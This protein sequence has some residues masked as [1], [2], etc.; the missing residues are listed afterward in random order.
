MSLQR[1]KFQDSASLPRILEF[2]P[3]T[4]S[5]LSN[6]ERKRTF[7][8]TQTPTVFLCKRIYLFQYKSL[9][10]GYHMAN[11]EHLAR[12]KYWSEHSWSQEDTKPG[13]KKPAGRLLDLRNAD[14]R[15]ADLHHSD[16]H[17]THADLSGADLSG[18]NLCFA[19]QLHFLNV[20]QPYGEPRERWLRESERS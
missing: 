20:N 7:D 14:L 6:L 16:L 11:P 4:T 18:A 15:N 13:A 10:G 3:E 1:C 2:T 12:L 19:L 9:Q 5:V 17:H 8:Y